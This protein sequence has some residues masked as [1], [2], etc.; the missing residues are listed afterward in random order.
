[1]A[2]HSMITCSGSSSASS[3]N[4]E[5]HLV[6]RL[7]CSATNVPSSSLPGDDHLAAIA[8]GVGTVPL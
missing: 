6:I 2:P 3:W 7:S 5:G 4:L 1:M 8:E